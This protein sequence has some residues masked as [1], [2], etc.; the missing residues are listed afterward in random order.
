[1]GAKYLIAGLAEYMQLYKSLPYLVENSICLVTS[2]RDKIKPSNIQNERKE[3]KRR[4]GM[5]TGT[6]K[7]TAH[8]V[9]QASFRV[10]QAPASMFPVLSLCAWSQ[11]LF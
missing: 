5:E 7:I 4:T 3:K 1:M 11:I 10:S 8:S 9:G 2:S 6:S